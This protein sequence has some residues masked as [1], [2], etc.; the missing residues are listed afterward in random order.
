VE[1]SL[2]NINKDTKKNFV[3][4]DNFS[5]KGFTLV[6]SENLKLNKLVSKKINNRDLLIFQKNLKKNTSVKITNL[7]NNRSIIAKVGPSAIYPNFYNSV[8]STRIAKELVLTPD[9]PYVEI[10]ELINNSSF[11]A[12]VSKTYDEEKKV[13]SNAPVDEIKISDLSNN[14]K[15]EIKNNN[16]KKKFNYIIK[17]V[18]LY[19]KDSADAL[20]LRIKK[21]TTVNRVYVN[22]LS[23]SKY[24]VFLGPFDN[25][26]LLQKAY[27][28]IKIL[29][30]ENI[31]IVYND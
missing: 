11:V 29:E 7:I 17:V 3:K 9:E 8:I 22:K 5:N 30:F 18:D 1:T 2:R 16:N 6:Y 4:R 21:E 31:E 25:I 23:E 12:K 24:R 28:D 13:A 27:N 10:I 20:K 14:G 26:N 19:F 15:T